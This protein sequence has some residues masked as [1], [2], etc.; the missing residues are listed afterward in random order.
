M[1]ES[2]AH[3]DCTSQKALI[4]ASDLIGAKYS[5]LVTSTSTQGESLGVRGTLLASSM[6]T[7]MSGA[8]IAPALPAMQAHFVGVPGSE[9]GVRLVL[10][11]VG[12]AIALSSPLVGWIADRF[13]RKPLLIGSLLLYAAAGLSGY[14][15]ATLGQLLLGR[16][17]LGLAVAGTM[18]SSSA[19]IADYFQGQRRNQFVSIQSAFTGFGGVLFLPL[20][21]LLAGI[22]WRAPFFVYLASLAIV[23]FALKA[24]NEPPRAHQGH[25]KAEPAPRLVWGLYG[26]G[27]MGMA[28]FYIGPS[29]L[30]FRLER[31]FGIGAAQAGLMVAIM[32]LV[33]ALT[34][35]QYGRIKARLSHNQIA[36]IGLGLMG[37]GWVV[38]GIA[39]QVAVVVV[40]LILVGIG[41][42]LNN[43]NLS[44]WLMGLTHPSNRGRV[45]GGLSGSI[46]LGQFVSPLITQPIAVAA[47]LG[48]AFELVGLVS[49]V[50][51]LAMGLGGKMIGSRA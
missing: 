35:L 44:V 47:G 48:R 11:I 17:V 14:F 51:G 22:S 31:G 36:G 10:T 27:L 9:L 15:S 46:F 23:P 12:L 7:I 2:H 21:G 25:G 43:P 37:L 42:G 26:L 6:L 38:V 32:T 1:N 28:I 50:L 34:S 45:L 4:S 18:T 40:G 49:I 8:T 20:G 24:L 41:G 19:L 30:P 16:V 5:S 29:Q 33:N 3:S 13:G 39:P